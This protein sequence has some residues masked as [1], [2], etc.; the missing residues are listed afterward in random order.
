MQEVKDAGAAFGVA[1][2]LNPRVLE[3]AREQ[4]LP[5]APGVVTPSDIECALEH[6]CKTLKFFP[7]EPSGGL[8]YLKSRAAPYFDSTTWPV[9]TGAVRRVSRVPLRSSSAKVRIVMSGKMKRNQ[10]QKTGEWKVAKTRLCWDGPSVKPFIEVEIPMPLKNTTSA[11][12][13]QPK[14]L[15]K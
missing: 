15:W 9:L 8:K 12:I 1:P 10:N 5:F 7:A 11:I 13:T 3:A 2:G 6:G 14:G 4:E